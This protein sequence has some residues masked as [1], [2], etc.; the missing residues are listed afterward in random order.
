MKIDITDYNHAD[1]ILNP[2]LWKEIEET[3]LKMPLHVK[4][5]DQASKVGSLIFD[6]VGT[7]QYIKDELVPKHWKNNIPIPKRF[8]FL[9]TDI[10]FGKRDTLVEV[11]FSNYPFLLNNTV[12]SELFHKS[13][14]DIDE[15]GM[16]VAIIITK[17]HMFPASNSSLYYEQAQ[18]QLNSLAEYNVFDVPIRLVG[19]IED[20]ETD[21]DIVSTTYADKRYSRTITKRDT[22]KGKVI[23]TNTPNT[24]RRKRGTIVTY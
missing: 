20:F 10:D 12:R 22:V 7:N 14:M 4:A 19:L 6:P 1:E 24:R 9:G 16:K 21:I 11:Q 8:D 17:G 5:S 23:D 13:N 3:L 18:N 2:Q 15:E